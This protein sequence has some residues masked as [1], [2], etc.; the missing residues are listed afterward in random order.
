MPHYIDEESKQILLQLCGM[1]SHEDIP[2]EVEEEYWKFKRYWDR[3]YT[4]QALDRSSLIYMAMKHTP[5]EPQ[6]EEYE[7]KPTLVTH[8]PEYDEIVKVK[9]RGEEARA[10]FKSISADGKYVHV[11]I[12][13]DPTAEERLIKLENVEILEEQKA[14]PVGK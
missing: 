4:G 10:Y 1:K 12:E 11:L 2:W 3:C 5:G 14:E 6:K 7:P 9:W 8:K 13:N